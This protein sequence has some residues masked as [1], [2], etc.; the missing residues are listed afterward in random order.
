MAIPPRPYFPPTTLVR[1]QTQIV[2]QADP[3]WRPAMSTKDV[4]FEFSNGRKFEA[5]PN[6]RFPYDEV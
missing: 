4:E 5:V 1:T 2:R 6:T 3:N